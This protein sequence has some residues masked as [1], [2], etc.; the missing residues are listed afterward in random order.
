MTGRLAAVLLLGGLCVVSALA[1]VHTTHASRKLFVE[2]L[3]LQQVQDRLDVEWGQLL[4]EQSTWATHG[5]LEHIA[6]SRLGMHLP[7]ADSIVILR[8]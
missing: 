3:S 8:R 7:P 2:I 1:V 4:L 5:R 6:S